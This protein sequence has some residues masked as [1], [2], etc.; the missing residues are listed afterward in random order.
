M[1]MNSIEPSKSLA[2]AMDIAKSI[3][4]ERKHAGFAG[5]HFF[6]ALLEDNDLKKL[7]ESHGGDIRFLKDWIDFGIKHYPKTAD[8]IKDISPDTDI[9]RL[10]NEAEFV[11]LRLAK[12]EIDSTCALLAILKPDIVFTR[13]ELKTLSLN[14][15]QIMNAI[16]ADLSAPD[17]G[18]PLEKSEQ[19]KSRADAVTSRLIFKYCIDMTRLAKEGKLDP[20]IGRDREIQTVFEILCRRDKN[21]V[22]IIGEPGVGKTAIINGL[23]QRI[24]EGRVPSQLKSATLFALDL[25]SLLAGAGYKGEF[26]ERLKNLLSELKKQG[27]AILF[28]DDIHALLESGGPS[29]GELLKP[30]L[31]SQEMR[32]IGIATN[33]EY[34][35]KIEADSALDRRF[36]RVTIEE[37]DQ[38]TA[39]K[40]ISLLAPKFE[41]HYKIKIS[42]EAIAESVRLSKRYLAERRLPDVAIDLIDRALSSIQLMNET[43]RD[44]IRLLSQELEELSKASNSLGAEALLEKLSWLQGD[45]RARISEVLY[46]QLEEDDQLEGKEG[47][48]YTPEF[49]HKK[50]N[51]Q[52]RKLGALAEKKK[53]ALEASDVAAVVAGK[54]GIPVGRLQMQEREK[55]LKMQEWL[56]AKVIGQ[57]HVIQPLSDAIRESRAGLVQKD[58]PIGA[59]FLLGP[60]GTGK[61]ETAKTLASF[62]FD[63]ERCMIRY[64]MSEFKEEHSVAKLIGAPPGYIGFGEGGDLVNKIREKPYSVVLFDEIEKAHKKIFDLFLQILDEGELHDT[65]GKRGDFSNAVILFTSNIASDEIVQTF[66][67][68]ETPKTTRLQEIMEQH[69]RPEFLGR[70]TDILPFRQLTEENME[71]IFNIQIKSLIRTLESQGI[72]LDIALDAKRKLIHDGYSPKLGARPLADVIRKEIRRP[73]STKIIS[74]EMV[75]GS[76]IILELNEAGNFSWN[77]A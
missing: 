60:T 39:V 34:R 61:T 77:L 44:E 26:E 62:L 49:V 66:Q 41:A 15:Q 53:E 63:D 33:K 23:A 52:L 28:V 19:K 13:E 71:K 76:K 45:I 8:R 36:D 14:S 46:N 67:K 17:V 3:A 55:L 43:A 59:F 68:G 64:N 11:R 72:K 74:G 22:L 4:I 32:I 48:F 25:S 47:T 54:T 12:K 65:Q 42:K 2:K 70:L 73:L 29:V 21:N 16:G 9:Q 40:I 10:L 50:L 51:T 57:D 35:E 30:E 38:D 37:P 7:I 20:V 31:T 56:K 1:P 18:A 58:K 24:A 75:S 69:F 27:N 6:K 5:I